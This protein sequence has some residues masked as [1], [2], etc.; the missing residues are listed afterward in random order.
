[1]NEF[2]RPLAGISVG[3]SISE[4]EDTPQ[5]GFP[6]W[7]VNRVTLQV[8]AALFS[9]GASV[10]FGH[11][12]REDGVMEAV[13]GFAQQVQAPVPLSRTDK[14]ATP[15]PLLRNLVAWP[16]GPFLKEPELER[17][18][19][20]LRVE[21]A[22]LPKELEDVAS[23]AQKEGPN[24]LL[25]RF[26]RAVALSTLRQR[27]NEISNA[28]LCLGG[29]RS[30][31]AGRYPGIIEEALFALR[32]KKPLY[33]T[34]LLG[35]ASKQIVDAME[36]ADMPDDF[37]PASDL[38]ALFSKPPIPY[39]PTFLADFPKERHELWEEFRESGLEKLT[40]LN[41]LTPAEN[42]ELAARFWIASSSSC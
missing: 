41:K 10:V 2:A 20:T 3:V 34:G 31:F 24:G 16:D 18:S 29:R 27:L 21:L 13:H 30:R 7:Q 14:E 8:V 9:Q 42:E 36:G 40:N 35:G 32:S 11:D 37:C 33:V 15:Q 28:R 19:T 12:W 39:Y 1:M 23:R 26:V 38:Q 5:R 22:G 25:Y 4:N 17:L 6:P